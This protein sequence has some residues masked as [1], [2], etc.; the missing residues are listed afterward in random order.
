M[1]ANTSLNVS[2]LDFVGIR[3]NLVEFL[4]GRSE[5]AGFNFNDTALSTLIDLLAYNTYYT[6]YY[7]NMAANEGF[8]DTA[9]LY[10][11]V[12]SRAKAIGYTP[13]SA[14]GS[15]ANVQVRFTS[16]LANATF[17]SITVPKNTRFRTSINGISYIFVTPKSYTISANS[18]NRFQGYINI[19]EGEPLTH[20][21][22]FTA[23]NTSF[24]LPNAN[25]DVSS[26]AV[27]VT[28]SGNT[29]TY[30]EATDLTNANS[31][32]RLFFV[33]ADRNK[34]YKVGFGDGVLGQKPPINSTVT[35]S[36]RVCSAERAN[37]ANNFTAVSTVGGQSAFTLRAISR[38]EG[39]SA[40]ESIESIRFNAPRLYETQNRA[41]TAEDYRR[42]IVRD[43]PDLEAVSVWGGEENDPPIYGKVYVAAKPLLGT[44]LS[45]NRKNAI[46]S[47][48]RK[49]NVQSVDIEMTDPT[50]LYV[51]P[52][53]E[54]RYVPEETTRT[55]SEIAAAVA[56]RVR[57]F[58][59]EYLGKFSSRFRLSKFLS[60][61]DDADD[62][63]TGSRATIDIQKRFN[64]STIS[65]N[66]YV[67]RF[68]TQLLQLGEGEQL[69]T[70]RGGSSRHPGFGWLTSSSFTKDSF[71]SYLEDNG[72]GIVRVYYRNTVGQFDRVYT[73]RGAGTVDYKNGIVYLNAFKPDVVT[74]DALYLTAR[75]VSQNINSV[76]N[77]IIL[78]AGSRIVVLND[79]T[80]EVLA[81]ASDLSTLGDTAL[82]A[83][84]PGLTTF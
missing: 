73:D 44:L 59:T 4:Q 63:I 32:A 17:R 38:A 11:S 49:Y 81:R 26:I 16:A 29:Q 52:Y 25:T 42:I 14:R 1:A 79:A 18:S 30:V 10:E 77:Q 50:Y 37:G 62:A 3:S 33:E 35:V 69:A 8:L 19:V 12:A 39:G 54:V 6:S 22:T 40:A 72:F 31:S 56:S 83:D 27:T 48:M 70:V 75:P 7:A 84:S 58:E 82:I 28:S 55:A 24:V 66:D 68:N 71:T 21:F 53:V 51:V 46:V 78:L 80:S 43:N 15:S 41:V 57:S 74:G 36:Y 60:Y 34:L 9:Q 76:R 47:F 67:I 23:A 20:N 5:F 13:S 65:K 2:S 64:P 61:L 45:T